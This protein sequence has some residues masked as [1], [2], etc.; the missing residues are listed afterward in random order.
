[1][2]S[3]PGAALALFRQQHENL[4]EAIKTYTDSHR[5]GIQIVHVCDRM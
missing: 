3:L 2:L 5:T 4:F 1:M